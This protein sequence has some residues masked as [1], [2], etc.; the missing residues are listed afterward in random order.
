M[1]E[2][3]P[4]HIIRAVTDPNTRSALEQQGRAYQ[5][6]VGERGTEIGGG[7]GANV[8]GIGGM[9]N[10]PR[11]DPGEGGDLPMGFARPGVAPAVVVVPNIENRRNN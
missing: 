9:P 10:D 3:L 2:R 11:I 5:E 4:D 1:A 6:G 7:S 8:G